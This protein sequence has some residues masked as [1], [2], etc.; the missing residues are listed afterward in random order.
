MGI[1]VIEFNEVTFLA[2]FLFV[3][4]LSSLMTVVP[5]C[6]SC[7]AILV[8][9]FGSISGINLMV[10]SLTVIL[11]QNKTQ[12]IWEFQYAFYVIFI[13]SLDITSSLLGDSFVSVY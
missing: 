9:H 11:K 5:F 12:S 4:T 13:F 3:P 7:V 10:H 8:E 6:K 2:S 1:S